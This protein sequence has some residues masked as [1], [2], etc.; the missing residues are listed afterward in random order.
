MSATFEP[1]SG[2]QFQGGKPASRVEKTIVDII[3]SP[4]LVCSLQYTVPAAWL[5][6]WLLVPL[7]RYRLAVYLWRAFTYLIGV[8]RLSR[9][10]VVGTSVDSMRER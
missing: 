10:G 9:V 1:L 4:C 3:M 5:V 7:L 6:V 8:R 2:G